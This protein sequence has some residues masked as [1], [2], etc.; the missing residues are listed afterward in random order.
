MFTL[1][2][3]VPVSNFLAHLK[4]T[5]KKA[6]EATEG[7][8]VI[9]AFPIDWAQACPLPPILRYV[10]TMENCSAIKGTNY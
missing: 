2:T 6:I 5:T 9:P 4:V 3:R 7:L 10:H 8:M 1:T